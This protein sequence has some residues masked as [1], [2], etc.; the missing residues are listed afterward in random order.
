MTEIEYEPLDGDQYAGQWVALEPGTDNVVG[1]G[2][3]LIVAEHLAKQA[4]FDE[5]EFYRVPTSDA[6]FVGVSSR[7]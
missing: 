1:Y 2:G 4:G 6:Y 7:A 5:P 3:T